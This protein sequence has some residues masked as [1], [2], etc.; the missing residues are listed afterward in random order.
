MAYTPEVTMS[1]AG[2]GG[3][4]NSSEG[5]P[6]IPA[7][8]HNG[9]LPSRA[10]SVLKAAATSWFVV[11]GPGQL[12][13]VVH[14][15]DFY[16][17]TVVLAQFEAWNQVFPRAHLAGDTVHNT[18]VAIHLAFAALITTSGLLQL[19]TG[20]AGGFPASTAGMGGSIWRRS[21]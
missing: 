9:A 19:M 12:I 10:N 1:T 20:Y 4:D 15:F 7:A 21:S 16:G 14:L 5:R 6:F 11:A 17:R 3:K 13:F 18:V 8:A 2:I